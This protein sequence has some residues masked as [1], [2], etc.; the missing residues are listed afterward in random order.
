MRS[1]H[2]P[3]LSSASAA[4]AAPAPKRERTASNCSAARAYSPFA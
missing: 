3:S 1:W 2:I 4:F